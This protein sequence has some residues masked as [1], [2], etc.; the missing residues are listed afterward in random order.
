MVLGE[1]MRTIEIDESLYDKKGSATE[2]Q[3]SNIRG[4]FGWYRKG[5][6]NHM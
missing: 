2:V 1:S 4:S 5:R 6:K 3:E